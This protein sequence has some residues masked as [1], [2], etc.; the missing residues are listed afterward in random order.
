[1]V[2]HSPVGHEVG[3]LSALMTGGVPEIDK[4]A[5]FTYI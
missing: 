5:P 4:D 3:T 1:M 2:R